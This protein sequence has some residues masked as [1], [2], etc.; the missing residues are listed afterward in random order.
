MS[1]AAMRKAGVTACCDRINSFRTVA[2]GRFLPSGPIGYRAISGGPVRATRT[3]AEQD[4]HF[5]MS[6]ECANSAERAA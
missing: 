1:R 2:V 3:E 6:P 4:Q 5:Y